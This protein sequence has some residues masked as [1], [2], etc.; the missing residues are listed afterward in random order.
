MSCNYRNREK[1]K[2]IHNEG[3]ILFKVASFETFDLQY[4]NSMSI[5]IDSDQKTSIANPEKLIFSGL[6]RTSDTVKRGDF[7]GFETILKTPS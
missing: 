3:F 6:S 1:V 2:K 4:W 5:S 7:E